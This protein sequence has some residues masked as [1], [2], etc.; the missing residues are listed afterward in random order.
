[1]IA[2][3]SHRD[4]LLGDSL[5]FSHTHAMRGNNNY[6]SVFNGESVFPLELDCIRTS[7]Y[8]AHNVS[9]PRNSG[10]GLVETVTIGVEIYE[11]MLCN[12]KTKK[13]LKQLQFTSSS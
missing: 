12:L 2:C 6:Y 13:K 1:M 7:F 10:G 5:L 11:G 4:Q 3:I 9:E 8:S